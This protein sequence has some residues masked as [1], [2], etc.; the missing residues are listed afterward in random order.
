[1]L[2]VLTVFIIRTG[3]NFTEN[4]LSVQLGKFTENL[5]ANFLKMDQCQPQ[6]NCKTQPLLFQGIQIVLNG[7]TLAGLASQILYWC[8]TMLNGAE[9]WISAI[10]HHGWVSW[11]GRVGIDPFS[12][13]LVVKRTQSIKHK[14]ISPT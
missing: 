4:W 11:L 6:P 14:C 7:Q 5:S 13:N 2:R 10:Y 9:F 1:M 8:H 3:G 12:K